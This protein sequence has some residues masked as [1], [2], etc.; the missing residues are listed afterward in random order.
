MKDK[1]VSKTLMEGQNKLATS[2]QV[3][4]NMDSSIIMKK[5]MLKAKYT[6]RQD[7]MLYYYWSMF[8]ALNCLYSSLFY[9]FYT[10]NHFPKAW[11]R[12]FFILWV[13][14]LFFLVDIIFGFFT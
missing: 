3:L 2:Q 12:D 4:V 13:S 9:P 7:T 6:F 11:S 10:L 1:K 8:I 5:S 14:E